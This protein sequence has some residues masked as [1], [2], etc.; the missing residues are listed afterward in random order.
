MGTHRG[1]PATSYSNHPWVSYS[2]TVADFTVIKYPQTL[3]ALL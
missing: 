1:I 3:V 2:L